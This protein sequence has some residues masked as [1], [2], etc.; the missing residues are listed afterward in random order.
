LNDNYKIY[1]AGYHPEKSVQAK[2]IFYIK[3]EL[4]KIYGNKLNFKFVSDIGD[5]NY[6]AVDLLKLVESGEIDCCYFFSSYLSEKINEL[7]LFEIPFQ[8][9]N[10]KQVFDLLDGTVGDFLSNK[11]E[12]K[13][14]YK[15][16]GWWDNGIRHMS[17]NK[18]HIR[19]LED[20][21]LSTIRIA[22]NSM[23]KTAFESLG[24]KTKFIDVKNLKTAIQK[25]EI[26]TQEN[27][28]TN[29]I[30]YGIEDYHK[31]ITL[32]SHLYG[33]SILLCNKKKY[34]SWDIDFQKTLDMLIKKTTKYQRKLAI[35]EDLRCM[36]YLQKKGTKIIE[37][38]KS[39]KKNMKSMTLEACEDAILKF[40]DH[41]K[42]KYFELI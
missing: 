10:R 19:S 38:D 36:K 20:C 21:K 35:N 40:P 17:S 7:N 34:Y 15:V 6:N 5:L 11:V 31:Y 30:N 2:A 4:Y 39:L 12:E 28:L 13:T 3:D 29:I 16:L 33:T 1:W 41:I 25:N 24:F 14:G 32:S 37:L 18:T 42:Q 22:K 26:D 27:P 9:S 23:H 8:I